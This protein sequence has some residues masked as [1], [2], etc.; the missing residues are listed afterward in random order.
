MTATVLAALELSWDPQIRGILVVAFAVAVLCGS[1]YLLLGTNLGT[2]LGFLVAMAGF[3]GWMTIMGII[4]ALYGIGY[5]GDSP[6]WHVTE[7][8]S[9]QSAD[10]LSQAKLEAA[11]DLGDWTE[12]PADDPSRGEAQASASA[13]LVGQDS[14]FGLFEA[15]SEYV[16]V[17]AYEKGG[18]DPDSLLSELPGPHPPH[19]AIVQ[20][21]RAKV[22]EVE[23]G[24]TPPPAEADE[25][26]PIISVVMERDL[27]SKRLPPV[28]IALA[29]GIL[30]GITCNVLHR[31]DKAVT[32]ARAAAA[33]NA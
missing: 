17:D 15:E 18:K 3:W 33:A 4:W 31:R 2:R 5:V 8:V 1:V 24:D 27:G 22:V 12:L 14:V 32:E 25:T 16:V 10:D 21:Q 6:T 19:Y 28:A 7:A 23:F 26:Q 11:H 29:S 30:F 13:S 9:S 20:V